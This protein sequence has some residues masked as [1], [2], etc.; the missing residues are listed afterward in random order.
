MMKN[1]LKGAVNAV[2]K[3]RCFGVLTRWGGVI[4]GEVAP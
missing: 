1:N 2:V 4:Q 3:E